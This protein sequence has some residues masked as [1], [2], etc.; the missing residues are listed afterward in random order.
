MVKGI[1]LTG[2]PGTGQLFALLTLATSLY[3]LL[4]VRVLTNCCA[5]HSF[6]LCAVPLSSTGK[7][8]LAKAIAGEAQ[9]AFFSCSGSDFEEMFVGVGARRIRD[10][11][12][13]ARKKAPCIIFI[14][15]IDAVGSKRS[16]T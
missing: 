5:P 6:V 3:S 8:L 2:P 9:V 12:T 1:L 13:A 15:E 14:D 10:L 4:L 16:G 7:T 11:F